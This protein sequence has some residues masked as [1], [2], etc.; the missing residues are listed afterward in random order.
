M[1]ISRGPEIVTAGSVLILDAADRNSYPSSGTS[2]LDLSGGGN[3]ST[4]NNGPTFS[5][6]GGGSILLDGVDDYASVEN[7]ARLNPSN[8][9]VSIWVKRNA[10]QSSVA[11]LIRRNDIDSYA[12]LPATSSDTV[13]FTIND[14]IGGRVYSP[15]AGFPL[16]QWINIVGT[17]DGANI[18]IYKSGS[19][20]G[21]TASSITI[22]YS[23]SNN[24]MI[25]GRDD[26]FAGRYMSA[27]YGLVLIYSRALTGTETS[28]NFNAAR[29]RYG[30]Q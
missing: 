30:I 16:N 3:N 5:P 24:Q 19:P 15:T 28:Q 25:I 2:W 21:Q 13:R 1:A 26:A 18:S 14:G 9:T 6:S 29:G 17:H 22:S 23:A 4:L 8:V 12:I 27:N 7:T 10:Y 20:S 11:N